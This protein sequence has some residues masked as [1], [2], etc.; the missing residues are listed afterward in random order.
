MHSR[1]IIACSSGA[2]SGET[3]RAPIAR[4]ASLS[5]AKNWNEN[6]PPAMS[7]IVIA[8]A[9]AASSAAISTT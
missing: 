9:P 4:S 8:V 7:A 3:S 6:R 5:E 1:S 2:S